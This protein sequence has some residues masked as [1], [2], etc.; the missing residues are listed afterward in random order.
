MKKSILEFWV[1]LFVLLGIAALGVLAFR[2]AGGHGSFSGSRPTYTVYAEFADIGGLKVQAPIKTAGV[3]VGRVKDIQLD[4]KNFQAKVSLEIDK[5]YQYSSD[6]NA[7]ILTSGLLGEQYI[8]LNQGGEESKLANGDYIEMTTSALVLENMINQ[9]VGQL[10]N[11]D[12][13]SE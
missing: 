7:Q 1:G 4:P 2:V 11:K 12:K 8:G 3:L 9:V 10:M 6:A 5:Q 13:S